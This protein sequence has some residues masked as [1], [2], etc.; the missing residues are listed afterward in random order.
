LTNSHSNVVDS[1]VASSELR[2][3]RERVDLSLSVGMATERPRSANSDGKDKDALSQS[4]GAAL[5]KQSKRSGMTQ[6]R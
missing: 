2:P 6:A 5:A 4:Q 3:E 1:V